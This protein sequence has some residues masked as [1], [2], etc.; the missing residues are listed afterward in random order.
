MNNFIEVYDNVIT[1]EQC[2][3]I[4]NYIN[5]CPNI[6]RGEMG[7]GVDP[8]KKDSWDICNKFS[9]ETDVDCIVY[10]ALSQCLNDYKI[11]NP[12]LDGIRHWQLENRYNFQKYLPSGGYP[13]PHCESTSKT[14]SNR[15]L[16]WM[17]YLNT[18]T[19]QGGTK[20]P[21]YDLVTDAVAGRVVI[22]PT[23]WTHFHHGVISETQKK[24][25][26]TGWYSFVE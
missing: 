14:N 11:K 10:D 12:E 21:Q 9:N 25:I 5:T 3:S 2:N 13:Q 20:F 26:S 1:L 16:V 15:V 22:W 8:S 18:V 19:D 24:Y 6:E 4:V 17:I 23:S 7:S